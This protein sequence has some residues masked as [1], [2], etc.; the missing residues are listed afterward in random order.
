M[1]QAADGAAQE[2]AVA[3]HD[4]EPTLGVEV[5]PIEEGEAVCWNAPALV[6]GE[7]ATGLLHQL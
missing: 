1:P 3:V 7:E 2:V 6:V 5:E 4:R